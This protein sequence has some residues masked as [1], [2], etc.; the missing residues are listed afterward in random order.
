MV[1]WSAEQ[2]AAFVQMQFTAQSSHYRVQ[3]PQARHDVICCEGEPVGRLYLDRA[4]DRFHIL[5]LTIAPQRRSNGIGAVVLKEILQEADQAMKGITIY[6]EKDS[7]SVHFFER[8]GFRVAET[9]DYQ[10]L[11]ERQPASSPE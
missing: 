5:D 2:K 3:F 9:K 10:V 6:T 8:L 11:L 1:P 7:P 4:G